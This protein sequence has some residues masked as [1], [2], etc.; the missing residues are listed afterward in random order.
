LLWGNNSW[1]A[2]ASPSQES[3]FFDPA[4]KLLVPGIGP[5]IILNS[6]Y[7]VRVLARDFVRLT[8]NTNDQLVISA[9]H[10]IAVL[11]MFLRD[12]KWNILRKLM[13]NP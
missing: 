11:L 10:L 8:N 3:R 9:V 1:L 2:F 4:L 5:N 12:N 7:K 13:N 6:S